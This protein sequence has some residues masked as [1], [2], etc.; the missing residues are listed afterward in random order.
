[1]EINTPNNILYDLNFNELT[2]ISSKIEF[3]AKTIITSKC[4]ITDAKKEEYIKDIKFLVSDI[5]Y[6]IGNVESKYSQYQNDTYTLNGLYAV[7]L[8]LSEFRYSL[9]ELNK[10]LNSNTPELEFENLNSFFIINSEA[11]RKLNAAKKMLDK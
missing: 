3:L 2:D 1:N 11:N 8:M 6:L 5:N 4:S 10:Y 9:S 7:S